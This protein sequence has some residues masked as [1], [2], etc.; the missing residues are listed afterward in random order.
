METQ[1]AHL[2]NTNHGTYLG[3]LLHRSHIFIQESTWI[4]AWQVVS[5]QKTLAFINMLTWRKYEE[6]HNCIFSGIRHTTFLQNHLSN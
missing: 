5:T 6:E 1:L 2:Y 4:S 3:G